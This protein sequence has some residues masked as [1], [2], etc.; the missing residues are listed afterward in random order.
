M[1]ADDGYD[2]FSRGDHPAGVR[3][4]EVRDASRNRAFP[5]EVWYPAAARHVGED[6]ATG[7]AFVAPMSGATRTQMAV[8]DADAAPGTW[9][10]VLYSHPSGGSR[11]SA[12]FLCTHLASHGYVVAALNHSEVVAPELVRRAGETEPQKLARWDAVIASRVPDVRALLDHVVR[13]EVSA[14]PSRIGIMG[15]SLGGWTALAT[16]DIEP[17]IRAVVALAPG[18]ASQSKPGILPVRLAFAW[19]RDVPSLLLAGESDGSLPLQGMFEIFE[20]T[21]A[22][23]RMIVLRRADHMH[24]MDDVEVLHEAVRNMPPSGELAW[25]PAAMRPI[26]E[27]ARGEQAHVFVRGLTVAHLD[28]VL[29]ESAEAR[30]FLDGDLEAALAVRGVDAFLHEA[31]NK[32]RQ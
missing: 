21:P 14:D 23:K 17:R 18:G 19:N 20:R 26:A 1:T 13:T 10:L 29:K 4:T 12:T 27:L 32:R 9:P 6:T 28:S 25:L 15:H 2:P 11:L 22:S 30:R 16:V 3:T 5:C 31:S 7:D 8:R 24:F